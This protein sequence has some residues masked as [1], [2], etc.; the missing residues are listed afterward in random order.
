MDDDNNHSDSNPVRRSR[1]SHRVTQDDSGMAF[2]PPSSNA[3]L[4]TPSNTKTHQLTYLLDASQSESSHSQTKPSPK[5]D[6]K[7]A[8]NLLSRFRFKP[9]RD[10]HDDSEPT[11]PTA[12]TNEDEDDEQFI[13][14]KSH[15]TISG[16]TT[17][18]QININLSTG[19]SL[20]QRSTTNELVVR[21]LVA[22]IIEESEIITSKDIKELAK[23]IQTKVERTFAGRLENLERRIDALNTAMRDMRQSSDGEWGERGAPSQDRWDA[24]SNRPVSQVGWNNDSRKG[25][26]YSSWGQDPNNR[27]WG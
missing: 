15:L 4:L 7:T 26:R 1:K 13:I 19:G 11:T 8:Q 23:A 20:Q 24:S 22:K 14:S 9:T 5:K 27:T 12:I 2:P 16:G 17:T 3:Y 6:K 10:N 25:K 18:P 21:A